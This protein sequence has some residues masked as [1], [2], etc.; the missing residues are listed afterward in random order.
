MG[1]GVGPGGVGGTSPGGWFGGCGASSPGAGGTGLCNRYEKNGAVEY[2]CKIFSS[3]FLQ[4]R[5]SFGEPV[6][7]FIDKK[8]FIQKEINETEQKR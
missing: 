5:V 7:S 2:D 8:A 4:V 3:R 1:F 6:R